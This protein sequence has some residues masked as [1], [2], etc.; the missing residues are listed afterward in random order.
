MRL[1]RCV[2][3]DYGCH[4]E[5]I[6]ILVIHILS[7]YD[8]LSLSCLLACIYIY[9]P[10]CLTACM[11]VYLPALLAC[12]HVYTLYIGYIHVQ[13][14]VYAIPLC[15]LVSQ[16]SYPPKCDQCVWFGGFSL[17]GASSGARRVSI[18]QPA[19][20]RYQYYRGAEGAAVGLERDQASPR[21]PACASPALILM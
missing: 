8:C 15:V 2:I 21:K 1:L 18:C 5:S 6:T 16:F 9:L 7:L 20:L 10:T 13:A 14:D 17:V 12:L 11:T 19:T 4:I 3:R